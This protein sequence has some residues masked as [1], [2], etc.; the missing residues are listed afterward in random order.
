MCPPRFADVLAA[1][2][3]EPPTRPTPAAVLERG[4]PLPDLPRYAAPPRP[5]RTIARP[6]R[7]S[8]AQREAL[9]TFVRLGATEIDP[10]SDD[11][12]LRA[13]FRTLAKTTHPDRNPHDPRAA[14]RFAELMTAWERLRHGPNDR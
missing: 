14:H 10:R 13:A 2:L 5:R 4:M 1:A 7:W 12:T 8:L 6:R 11:A 3:R 9:A